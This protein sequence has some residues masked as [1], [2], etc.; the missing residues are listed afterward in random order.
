MDLLQGGAGQNPVTN[1]LQ[2]IQGELAQGRIPPPPPE[3]TPAQE[4]H[5]HNLIGIMA[6]EER[7]A[8]NLAEAQRRQDENNAEADRRQELNN[9]LA[10]AR[11]LWVAEY[12]RET[13]MMASQNT[14][15][16]QRITVAVSTAIMFLAAFTARLVVGSSSTTDGADPTGRSAMST[17][18]GYQYVG[19]PSRNARRFNV[20]AVGGAIEENG[21]P[22][23]P[24]WVRPDG[25]RQD[26]N[27]ELGLDGEPYFHDSNYGMGE[28]PLTTPDPGIHDGLPTTTPQ[29]TGN[30]KPKRF[31]TSPE[32]PTRSQTR[33]Y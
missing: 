32:V 11:A 3:E 4:K 21:V 16:G 2:W 19:P 15:N 29:T 30:A 28:M 17:N 13:A 12:S 6:Y 25:S 31:Q 23:M 33:V 26:P 20:G 24:D 9:E 10:D 27:G 7:N 14:V 5:R 8:R 1:Y 22:R 18:A